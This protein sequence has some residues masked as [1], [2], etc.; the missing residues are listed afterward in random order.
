MGEKQVNEV[1]EHIRANAVCP[2]CHSKWDDIHFLGMMDT[3]C[4]FHMRCSGC[5]LPMF[6]SVFP[7]TTE[8][9]KGGIA[10]ME[11]MPIGMHPEAAADAHNHLDTMEQ[12]R[13]S[14]LTYNDVLDFHQ[15]LNR[16]DINIQFGE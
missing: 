1:I 4:F 7:P 5:K 3:A 6:C 2:V 12:E 9:G 11:R 10:T 15:Y 8:G 16:T 14:P 13:T